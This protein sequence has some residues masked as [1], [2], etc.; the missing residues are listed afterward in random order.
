MFLI[1][2]KHNDENNNFVRI[3]QIKRLQFSDSYSMIKLYEMSFYYDISRVLLSML[4]FAIGVLKSL[5]SGTSYI[6]ASRLHIIE[7]DTVNVK[8]GAVWQ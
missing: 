5:M 3:K 7:K 1:L 4:G 2:I 8:R 6:N